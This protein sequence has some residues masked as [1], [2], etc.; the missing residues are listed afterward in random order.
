MELKVKKVGLFES[1]RGIAALVVVNEHLMKLFFVMAFSDAAMRSTEFGVL[2]E[3]SFPPFNMLHNGAWAVCIFFV[4]SG[5]V[6][7][8]SFFKSS[9]TDGRELT[10]KVVARYFRLA[11]PVTASL[12]F[13]MILFSFSSIYFS[14]IVPLTQSKELYPYANK[15]TVVDMISQ[16]FGSALFNDNF[17]YNPPLWTMSVE[18]F[19]SLFI[20]ALQAIFL[21]FRSH[22][23]AWMI[24]MALYFCL[25]V[26][27]FPTLYS[28]FV[29]GMLLC[30]CTL[31][32]RVDSFLKQYSKYWVP[33]SLILG[34]FL[35]GYMIRGLYT[36]PYRYITI[37]EFHPY[38][39]YLYNIW[40]AF[41]LLSGICYSETIKRILEKPIFL[42]LG[43]ISFSLYL[44]H[45]TVM[46]SLTSYLYMVLDINEH[47]I[48]AFASIIISLPVMFIVAKI[49]ESY[50]NEPTIKLSQWIKNR[51]G[52][53][54][55][56]RRENGIPQEPVI[57]S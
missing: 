25:I 11:I 47:T 53:K 36:N 20:F 2:E 41:F 17:S 18:M 3:M 26:L 10:G 34:L 12:I 21:T 45:Y 4:L 39:E 43:R 30:D 7:S 49:F 52:K 38:Y 40:G 51:I 13:V 48:R 54:V 15:P 5:Y 1:L 55:R 57:V 19:G 16:G 46:F 9:K 32:N 8:Y 37:N 22:K 6:L 44:T 31:N 24:R 28:G 33:F 56:S 29:L 50:V 27:L 23:Y 35:C 14:D 42:S